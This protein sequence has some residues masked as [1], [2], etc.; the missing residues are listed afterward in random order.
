MIGMM[1]MIGTLH[2]HT[3]CIYLLHAAIKQCDTDLSRHGLCS[4]ATSEEGLRGSFQC[5]SEI[6]QMYRSRVALGT[7]GGACSEQTL[8]TALRCQKADP[9]QFVPY[10]ISL[11]IT[12]LSSSQVPAPANLCSN[13]LGMRQTYKTFIK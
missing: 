10:F 2:H 3:I 7:Q 13:I 4:F 6:L 12:S 1:G 11:P 8:R 9:W 5:I